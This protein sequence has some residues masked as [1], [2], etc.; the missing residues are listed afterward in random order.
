MHIMKV[1]GIDIGGSGIKGCPVDTRTGKLLAERIRIPTPKPATAEALLDTISAIAKQHDWKGPVGCGFPGV[2]RRGVICT[3]A[4]LDKSLIGMNLYSRLARR[5][6]RPAV[7]INDA[8]AAGLAEMRF[9][10]GKGAKGVTLLMTVGTGIG[11]ALF[12]QGQLVPNLELGH[13]MLKLPRHNKWRDAERL[14]ADSARKRHELNWK[15]WSQRMNHYLAYIEQ[16]INPDLIIIG[17]GVAK[18]E[19][20]FGDYLRTK[21]ELKMATLQNQA[22]I[23]GAAIA[24]RP[25]KG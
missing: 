13:M 19:E 25:G 22:G 3:A 21:A 24:S 10:A 9:G 17:G 14:V 20:K 7:V 16:L 8:D 18:K 2:V 11:I 15:Q 6:G 5:I 4:N 23:V 1:L 12:T